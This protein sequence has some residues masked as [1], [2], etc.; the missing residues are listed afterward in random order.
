MKKRRL[1]KLLCKMSKYA[2]YS[3]VLQMTVSS[4]LLGSEISNGQVLDVS[5]QPNKSK[6]VAKIT[7][8]IEEQTLSLKN[9]LIVLEQNS[10]LKF[11]YFK[12]KIPANKKVKLSSANKNLKD[13]LLRLS[14]QADI[15]FRRI[16][17]RIIVKSIRDKNI[18]RI[19]EEINVQ[20]KSISGKITSEED[21]EPLAGVN[22]VVPGSSLGTI[23]DVDG[24]YKLSVPEDVEQLAFSF[25][26]YKTQTKEIG[27]QSVINVAMSKDLQQLSE[28]VVTA[29]GVER[30]KRDLGYSVQ[31]VDSE[32]LNKVQETNV[33]NSLS[34]R[35]A[36]VNITNGSGN[37][38]SSSRIVIR[39]ENTLGG[40]NQPLFVVDGVPIDNSNFKSGTNA[41]RPDA[42]GSRS[43][44]DF[45][46]TAADINPDDIESIN[47]LKGPNAAALYGSRAANG[48]VIIT[49]KSAR[50]KQ[51]LGVSI[52]SDI[53]F[54]SPL[55]LPDYQNEYGQGARDEFVF[56]DGSQG[57][58]GEGISYGPPL[59][60]G[61]E[62]VQFDSNGE[63]TPWVSH[64]DNVR[65]FFETG[66]TY[67]NN[68]AISGGSENTDFRLS[69]TNLQQEGM[70][71][72]TDFQRNSISL[73]TG[74]T[75]AD[76]FTANITAN[77][78]VSESD[79]RMGGGYDDQNVMKQFS[80]FGRQVDI[81]ALRQ[82]AEGNELNWNTRSNENPYFIT[83]YNTNG[84]KRDRIFGNIR[85]NYDFADW[86]TLMV[87]TG[88]DFYTDTR[89]LRRAHNGYEFPQGAYTE[90][91]FKVRENNSDFLL[92]FN[93]RL[94]SDFNFE[95]SVGGNHMTRIFERNMVRARQLAV[96]NVFNVANAEGTPVAENRFE[97]KQ[98]NSLYY[99]GQLSFRNYLFFDF[100][101]RNDWSSTLPLQNNA[102]FY[103][104]FSMSAIV[105]DILNINDTSPLSYAKVRGSWAQVG[106]D[107]DPYQTTQVFV[108]TIDRWGSTPVATETGTIRNPDLKPQITS[109]FEIGVDLGFMNDRLN[110]DFTYYNSETR[111][112]IL[113]AGIAPSTGYSS[114][115][116]NA[117]K[118]ENKGIE[119]SL[120]AYLVNSPGDGFDW[121]FTVNYARNRNKVI[122]LAEGVNRVRLPAGRIFRL[123][124][125]AAEGEPYGS[126]YGRGM[127]RN[128]NGEVIYGDNGL[129]ILES[130][131]R[132]R[133]NYQP[134]W[135]GGI[136]NQFSYKGF[137]LN[138][139]IDG[140]IGGEFYSG[141]NVIGRRSG[142]L[143][144][145]LPGREEGLV[146]DGVVENEDGSFSPNTT[147]VDAIN[148]YLNYYGYNNTEVSIFD[149][150]FI[151]LREVSL[152]YTLPNEL[153]GSLPFADI[154][155]ALVGRNL[156][157]L[158]NNVPNV[159]PETSI[160][161]DIAQGIEFGQIPT[162]RSY[163][164]NINVSF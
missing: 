24:N 106:S 131:G 54:Q 118:I 156:A 153:L 69:L 90:E 56:I 27:N 20:E 30:Q 71:P 3:F 43:A 117:G 103:P 151:K 112:Q 72:N 93:R 92:S 150:T 17:E 32:D 66:H 29:L 2:F 101:G 110:F 78:H 46:N 116:F 10:G 114:E 85:L 132:I 142:T 127:M 157:F 161:S 59:D 158:K 34:G 129:P 140:K 147:R 53:M 25:V 145:T 149:A 164:F 15:Y 37:V 26:G 11:T 50:K 48:V 152:S 115:T 55:K 109:S 52:S 155:L 16:N 49:T 67:T 97:E 95:L 28:V 159:D 57:D 137:N 120:N 122:E 139:L 162:A 163:G 12:G 130:E 35:I 60:E 121:N 88:T 19:H 82:F 144:A 58:G 135:I 33:I 5:N 39:G 102:Y 73:N 94:G 81:N 141:T 148:W 40:N 44:I 84:F 119:A 77:Y 74:T 70:V 111:N 42:G 80:W 9:A 83:F 13:A 62:F 107:T 75:I 61:L 21:G 105:S 41:F 91:V 64:P 76:N 160:A 22:V 134:D 108:S 14:K 143:A 18:Q 99:L 45:G 7:I 126:F 146:G 63:P 86:L 136:N 125:V 79:N 96:P 51:D 128:E 154:S 104:S 87:R 23:S 123:D 65:D 68:V 124:V 138:V 6:S 47:V 4:I 100:T 8:D 98:I 113:T 38:G 133:G 31:K 36:G 89:K 1:L